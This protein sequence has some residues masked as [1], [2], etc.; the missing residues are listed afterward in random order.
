MNMDLLIADFFEVLGCNMPA[1]LMLVVAM[2]V[3]FGNRQRHPVA[4]R[5]AML[6]F[7]WLLCTDI[8]GLAWLH[9]GIFMAFPG[10][11]LDDPEEVLSLA[12]C[13]CCE[14]LGYLFLLLALKAAFTPYRPRPTYDEFDDIDI[15]RSGY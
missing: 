14:G 8:V 11:A 7:G 9:F 5:W 2:G 15:R 1:L 4:A 6:G 3:I 12:A 10:V 13:S